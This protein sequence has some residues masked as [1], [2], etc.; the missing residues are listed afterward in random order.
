MRLL[1]KLT[2]AAQKSSERAREI[3]EGAKLA[4]SIDTLRKTY[5]NEQTNLKK[6]RDATLDEI[7]LE[8]SELTKRRDSLR[9]QI[10]VMEE[11]LLN[12]IIN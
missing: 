2:L 4:K 8:I 7:K 5:A 3:A 6:F 9:G 10:H 12:N 1:D 11:K